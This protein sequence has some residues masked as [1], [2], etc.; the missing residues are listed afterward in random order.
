V[1]AVAAALADDH[2]P[3]LQLA[4]DLLQE[5][6]RNRLALR[7]RLRVERLAAGSGQLERGSHRVVR[8]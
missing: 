3:A 6:G 4:E 5:R 2:P 1:T 8:L 7:D